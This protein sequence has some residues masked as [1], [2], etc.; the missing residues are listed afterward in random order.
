MTINLD[1]LKT[2][3][4]LIE[5]LME[6]REWSKKTLALVLSIDEATLNRVISAKRP[7]S[8]ELAIS[9]EDVFHEPAES[10]LQLQKKHELAQARLSSIPD[11]VRKNRVKLYG[12]LKVDLLIK[13][14]WLDISDTNDITA[15]EQAVVKF[16]G[17]PSSEVTRFAFAAKKS[18]PESDATFTQLAWMYR[19]KQLAHQ[20]NAP[21]YS[22][23]KLVSALSVLKTKMVDP[24]QIKEVSGILLEAGV[25]LVVVESLPSAKIDGVCLWLNENQPVIGLS[26]RFDRIDNFWFVLRHELEHVLSGDGKTEE[27]VHVD[28]D[29][30][31]KNA[32]DDPSLSE[33]EIRANKA[34]ANFCV[35]AQW[36]DSFI[37][38][39]NPYFSDRK[40]VE[41]ASAINVHPGIVVGQL[42]NK[43][44]RYDRFRSHLVKIRSHLV[45]STLTD[46]WGNTP[47]LSNLKE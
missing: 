28:A 33:C 8:A 24:A 42:Q 3:G 14:G 40:V 22:Q 9:L 37:T 1:L 47:T 46:G 43:T 11:P 25:R 35:N 18:V 26:A 20:I 44:A 2:P 29:L 6:T 38:E 10:F 27:Y 21:S 36:M 12:D 32:G 41:F 30:V 19:V 5:H 39:N 16:F 17:K 7:L 34:A 4:Q 23:E 15:I 13:R 31:G 45:N